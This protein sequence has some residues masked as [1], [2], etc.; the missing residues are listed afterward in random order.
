MQGLDNREFT[1]HAY[2][3]GRDGGDPTKFLFNVDGDELLMTRAAIFAD[4]CY[5]RGNYSFTASGISSTGTYVCADFGGAG[6]Y[7]ASSMQVND[8]GVYSGRLIL[9]PS[10]SGRPRTEVQAGILTTD[11]VIGD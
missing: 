2:Y 6:T 7:Q 5:L 4:T 1:G 9:T 11:G 3:E 8:L 10:G